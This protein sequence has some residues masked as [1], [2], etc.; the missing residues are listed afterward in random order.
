MNLPLSHPPR[1]RDASGFACLLY[2]LDGLGAFTGRVHFLAGGEPCGEAL[3]DRGDLCYVRGTPGHARLGELLVGRDPSARDAVA[4]GVARARARGCALG[5]ALLE[6]DPRHLLSLRGALR[7]QMLAGLHSLAALGTPIHFERLPTA[8]AA[9]GAIRFSALEL[10]LTAAAP[11]T[12]AL[13]ALHEALGAGA[14]RAL[15]AR[16]DGVVHAAR[17]VASLREAG[18]LARDGWNQMGVAS[19]D[20]TAPRLLLRRD[21]ETSRVLALHDDTLAVF[22]GLGLGDQV[23]AMRLAGAL[24]GR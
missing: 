10:M 12:E 4:A 21:G 9:P 18:R 1:E 17:G 14:R 7:D 13:H 15:L 24:D 8:Q 16:E 3:L 19:F 2:A 5:T 20:G 6:D 23:R 22:E 11:A